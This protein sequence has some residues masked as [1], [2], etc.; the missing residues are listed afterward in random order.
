MALLV[1]NE[2]NTTSASRMTYTNKQAII[3]TPPLGMAVETTL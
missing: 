1:K 2:Q 3:V